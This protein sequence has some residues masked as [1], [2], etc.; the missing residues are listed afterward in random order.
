MASGQNTEAS[1]TVD[2][3]TSSVLVEVGDTANGNTATRRIMMK[4]QR[5]IPMLDEAQAAENDD[6]EDEDD[7]EG[8]GEGDDECSEFDTI[9]DR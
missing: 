1:Q 6:T 9:E 8:E 5:T 2:A 4:R 7:D 3:R